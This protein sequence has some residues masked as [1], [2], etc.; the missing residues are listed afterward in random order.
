MGV[1]LVSV[2]VVGAGP[3]GLLAASLLLDEGASPIVVAAG[4]GSLGLW[5]G[6]LA[7]PRDDGAVERA[8]ASLN[9]ADAR[10]SSVDER[11]RLIGPLGVAHRFAWAPP[12]LARVG[13]EDVVGFCG[14]AEMTETRAAVAVATWQSQTGSAAV[15]FDLAPWGRRVPFELARFLGHLEGARALGRAL[16]PR[17]DG[18]VSVVAVPGLLGIEDATRA[19]AVLEEMLERRVGEVPLVTPALAGWRLDRRVRT[20]L[21]AR[22]AT[23]RRARVVEVGRGGV[24]LADG[25]HVDADAVVLATGGVAGGGI[26]IGPDGS[27]TDSARGVAI[28]D[29]AAWMMGEDVGLLGYR[30]VVVDEEARVVAVGALR[31]HEG[32]GFAQVAQSVTEAV[33]VLR[34][35]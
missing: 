18:A 31:A 19:L 34:S 27:L 8:V 33:E 15:G 28:G 29:P 30:E 24:R 4:E 22:G 26:A 1:G 9:R 3:S 5:P 7:A 23:F 25:A 12:E 10:L 35:W 32:S 20:A 17:V 14:F 21:A 2:V 13:P 11:D 16:A 6:W